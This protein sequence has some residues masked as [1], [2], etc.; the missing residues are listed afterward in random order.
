MADEGELMYRFGA[1]V[2]FALL[3]HQILRLG[4]YGI[5]DRCGAST[6]S[7]R[8]PSMIYKLSFRS[9]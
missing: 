6:T 7:L 3:Y 1:N 4:N 9:I 8:D 2:P 5:A